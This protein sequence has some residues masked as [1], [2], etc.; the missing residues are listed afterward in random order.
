MNKE[1]VSYE[2]LLRRLDGELDADAAGA[3]GAHVS[4]CAECRQ[5]LDRLRALSGAIV[6]S[7]AALTE[8]EPRGQRRALVAAMEQ[9]AAALPRKTYAILAAAASVILVAGIVMKES[10]RPQPAVSPAPMA[11]E[12]FIA[13]PYSDDSL[14]SE[15][16][17][18]LQVELPRSAAALAGMPVNYS[19]GNPRV[20]AE[21]VVGADG[22]ARAIRFLD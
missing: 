18:V 21:V 2:L 10:P 17:V 19:S 22:L 11:Q 7:S 4:E 3:V 8:A 9:R 14:S 20:K 5:R 6:A 12:A 13:L 1:H 16:A 15:G